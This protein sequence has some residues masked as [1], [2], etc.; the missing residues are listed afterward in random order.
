M[1]A[2]ANDTTN[3]QTDEINTEMIDYMTAHGKVSARELSELVGITI[4]SI[5]YRLF[6]LMGCG[7]VGQEKTRNYR[8]WFYVTEKEA[9]SCG[10]GGA[11]IPTE[12]DKKG[13]YAGGNPLD[14]K[15]DVNVNRSKVGN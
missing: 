14:S 3:I 12:I 9:A 1:A 7:V 4:S 13:V 11:G 10:S 6:Q 8:V 15:G 5:R 2:T